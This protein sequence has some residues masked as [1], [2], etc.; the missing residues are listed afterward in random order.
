MGDG[1]FRLT[2][3]RPKLHK[4]RN[5]IV[6]GEELSRLIRCRS[7]DLVARSV[8]GE[9]MIVMRPTCLLISNPTILEEDAPNGD[10]LFRTVFPGLAHR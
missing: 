4:A 2:Y 8:L 6:A 10:G 9:T 3:P 5:G 7:F 1:F